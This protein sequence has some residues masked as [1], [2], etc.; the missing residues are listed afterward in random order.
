MK[1]ISKIMSALILGAALVAVGGP[2]AAINLDGPD[3]S[4][5]TGVHPIQGQAQVDN[6]TIFYE[7]F[8]PADRETVLLIA[9]AGAQMTMWSNGLCAELVERGYRV[10]RFDNRDTGLSTH[11]DHLGRPDWVEFFT[12]AS[13][14]RP[15]PVP[16]TIT[17]MANDS[18]GLLDALGIERA[19]IVGA[20]MGGA[21][22]Q[23]IAIHH[24]ERTCSLTLFFSE[25]GNP[26]MPGPTEEFLALPPP[27]P[28][29]S[30]VEAIVEHEVLVARTLGSPAYPTGEDVLREYS[31]QN[32][33]RDYDPIAL[34]RHSAA[35]TAESD[36]R[37]LLNQ[38]NVSTVILHG[39]SDI[40][41]PVENGYD[42]AANI[43]GAD[44]IVVPGMGHDIPEQL[45]PAFADAI[46]QAAT[47][48]T[49]E[50]DP[51]QADGTIRWTRPV[52]PAGPRLFAVRT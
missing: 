51:A 31:R 23:R 34:E 15:P 7:V 10:V 29:G 32:V 20:S 27:P 45:E 17:D 39:D 19:H 18:V 2:A 35:I 47:N 11:L 25:T 48:A 42:L 33:E 6:I 14:G 4:P 40:L 36:R 43:P 13:E 52:F 41:V 3:N 30:D 12:A 9:G 24:P 28:A 16:Y 22:A 21:I 46:T 50:N 1:R 44:L 26:E 38:L 8:G 37:E 5:A 49:C